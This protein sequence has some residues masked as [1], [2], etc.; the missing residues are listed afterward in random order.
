[1]NRHL[2]GVLEVLGAIDSERDERL[3][4]SDEQYTRSGH[5]GRP[6]P[7]PG[8]PPEPQTRLSGTRSAPKIDAVLGL[9]CLN[10]L[11]VFGTP[12]NKLYSFS[13]H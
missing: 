6:T 2:D 7:P 11:S 1:M 10:F 9:G 13:L 3:R 12:N 5:A 4:L 8:R